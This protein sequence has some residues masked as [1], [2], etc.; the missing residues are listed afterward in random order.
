MKNLFNAFQVIVFVVI[1]LSI[2]TVNAQEIDENNGWNTA[3]INSVGEN[4]STFYAQ[5]FIANVDVITRFGVVIKEGEAEGQVRLAIATDNGLGTPDV[6]TPLYQGTIINPAITGMW[7]YEAGLNIKVTPGEK[8]W[9]L[10]DGYANAGATGNAEIGISA[11]KPD[12]GEGMIY[13][14]TAGSS[15]GMVS[16]M[17]LA[18]RVEGIKP[19][20]VDENTSWNTNCIAN[21]GEGGTDFYAQ[22]FYA[23]VDLITRFGVVIKETGAEGQVVLS[24]AADNG[25]DVPDVSAPLYQGALINPST[26]GSWY[27]EKGLGIPVT[28]GQKYW[29]LI[30]GYTNAGAT[31][32]S[33][34]GS[35]FD[36]TDTGEGMIYSYS[37]G[38]GGWNS[39]PST[40]IAINVEGIKKTI[41]DENNGYNGN[42]VASIGADGTDYYAQSFYASID[43]ITNFGVYLKETAS[44]GEVTLAIAPNNGSGYPNITTPLYQGKLLNPPS[45]GAWFFEK[46]INI[47][48]TVGTKY[49]VVVGG[50]MNTGA[51]GRSGVGLSANY[52]DTGEP[53]IFS[54]EGGGSWSEYIS[55]LAVFIDGTLSLL[56]VSDTIVG[57]SQTGC[58]DATGTITV[59]GSSTVEFLNGSSADLIAGSSISLLPG[60]HAYNGSLVHAYITTSGDYCSFALSSPVYSGPYK[61]T[62][63]TTDEEEFKTPEAAGG[64]ALKVYPNPTTGILTVEMTNLGDR[65]EITI[66]NIVGEVVLKSHYNNSEGTRIDLSRFEKG[67]YFLQVNDGRSIASRKILKN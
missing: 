30:D 2:T 4:G 1:S 61:S 27:Y 50:Y 10:I 37:G 52:S 62:V 57:E 56:A 42:T 32:Y 51:T 49:W 9:V 8:Y 38:L 35:S 64:R 66:L 44:E 31:G 47:P 12:T 34:I 53:M 19:A 39:I 48:V 55:P 7:Y 6:T 54:N 26:T 29:V 17:P 25:F 28:I 59:A 65:G 46:G 63:L 45:G 33:E 20:T 3:F 21:V 23:D 43:A 24:I 15:W 58:F 36:F 41:I 40:P 22:S 16:S 67:I 11:N 14:N 13:S 18:I 5:S 60:F